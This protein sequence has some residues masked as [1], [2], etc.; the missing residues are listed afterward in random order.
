MICIPTDFEREK[1]QPRLTLDASRWVVETIGF[2]VVQAALGAAAAIARHAPKQLILVGIAGAFERSNA[3]LGEALM[4]DSVRIDG[5]GVGQGMEFLDA[6]TLGWSWAGEEGLS[7]DSE[8]AVAME[9]LTVCAASRD[10]SDAQWRSDRFPRAV[11]EDM[12]GYSVAL[13]SQQAGIPLT[14]VRGISNEVGQRDPSDWRIDDALIAAARLVQT[15]VDV[16]R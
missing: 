11:A 13:A 2:G 14:I 3:G 12:E 4:F 6:W 15:R 8:G 5:L 9:L 16:G 10:R 1:L 7:L